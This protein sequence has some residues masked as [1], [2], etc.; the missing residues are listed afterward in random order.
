MWVWHEM[1]RKGYGMEIHHLILSDTSETNYRG[2]P[3]YH[4]VRDGICDPLGQEDDH[5][6][7]IREEHGCKLIS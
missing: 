4:P 2:K 7:R 5:G 1:D 3:T 6:P